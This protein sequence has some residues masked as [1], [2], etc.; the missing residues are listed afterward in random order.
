V[1]QKHKK[2]AAVSNTYHCLRITLSESC[3]RVQEGEEMKRLVVL[4]L[5]A[6]PF[7]TSAAAGKPQALNDQQL[8]KVV[9]GF[10]AVSI[11]NAQGA[12]GIFETLKTTTSSTSE[13]SRSRIRPT[14]ASF[15]SS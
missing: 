3:H 5:T 15:G 9:A 4:A 14:T 12:V 10:S 13:V 11:A 2:L 1:A 7:M 6:L 8:D